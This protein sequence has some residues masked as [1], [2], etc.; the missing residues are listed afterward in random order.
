VIAAVVR[1]PAFHRGHAIVAIAFLVAAIVKTWPLARFWHV[2]LPQWDDSNFNVWRL[3]WVAHQLRTDP[4]HL[5]DTNVFYP[6]TNTLAFSDA[7]LFL[8]VSAAPLIW[9]GIHPFIVHNIAVIASFW[10]AAYCCYRLCYRLTGRMA[11][12]ILGGLVFGFA[13]YR[14]G[15]IAHL[16]L[17][18]TVFM[19]VGLLALIDLVRQPSIKGGVWLGVCFVLQTL[20]SVYYG[21]FF[22]MFLAGA[23]I[24]LFAIEWRKNGSGWLKAPLKAIAVAAALAVV[25][26]VPY[27]VKYAAA[28]QTIA[29]RPADEI[30]RFS[31]SPADYLRVARDNKVLTSEPKPGEEELSLFPGFVAIGLVLLAVTRETRLA[32][33]YVLL[34][35][36]TVELSFGMHGFVYP[37]MVEWI[38]PLTGLRAPARFGSLVLLTVAVL[39][40]M[41][42]ARLQASRRI[43]WYVM[44]ALAGAMLFEYWAVP[45]RTRERP[46]SPPP[47]YAWLAQQPPGVLV[48]LPVP[49][50]DELWAFE[51][52]YQLM[53]IYHW[54]RLLN[55]YSGSAPPSYLRIW[56]VMQTFPSEDAISRLRRLG[57]R[58]VL[59]HEG[60]MPSQAFSDLL[61]RVT[62]SG[63]FR[64]LSTFPD[65]MGKAVVLE[66]SDN[67]VS[68][69]TE[70]AGAKHE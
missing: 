9:L 65:G 1:R 51:T 38:P 62:Q 34:L 61:L 46:M 55:G 59:V 10:L 53:S 42:A 58:W 14:Y 17:L 15:H 20:C 64:I 27:A 26:L 56:E 25:L 68:P 45:L 69:P 49:P 13:P 32:M 57:V 54:Q 44:P 67:F 8:G 7:M 24:V 29:P 4:L 19:P 36:F 12:S 6:A 16:E 23:T 28:R 11:P 70:V 22:S 33:P 52:E 39:A 63:A 30:S 48:E 40:A 18:W 47:A 35:A 41:G 66:L 60:L 5:F 3:A 50:P 21:V 2:V 31:A 43:A 37:A